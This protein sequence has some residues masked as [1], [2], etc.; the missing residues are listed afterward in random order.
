[1][2]RT[3]LEWA[4]ERKLG[5]VPQDYANDIL[6]KFKAHV[7]A[8]KNPYHLLDD[9]QRRNGFEACRQAIIKSLFAA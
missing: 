1:M 5:Y 9:F 4:I 7:E 3:D 2:L 6:A 8:V